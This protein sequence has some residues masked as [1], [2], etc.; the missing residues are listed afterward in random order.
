MNSY[1]P[2]KLP[3][4]N[5]LISFSGGR[6]SG[7]MLYKILEANNGLPERCKVVFANTGREMPETLEFI[8]RC[9]DEW[10]VEIIWLEYD[11]PDNKVAYKQVNFQNASRFGEPFTQLINHKKGLP[12]VLV[13]FCTQEL[14]IRTINRYLKKQG[15]KNWHSAIGIRA[16]ELRRIK[17]DSPKD[18]FIKWY[19]LF[20]AKVTK[21][22]IASFWEKHTFDLNLF[23]HNGQAAKGN[24]DGCFLKSEATLAMMWREHPDRMQWWADIEDSQ[25]IRNNK[26]QVFNPARTF[27][28]LGDFVERQGDW[29]FNDKAMLCQADDGE[30]TGI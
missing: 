8:Q 22:T 29:I 23:A 24:C 20:D 18:R 13:R 16:D 25:P 2:Y 1:N 17:S 26:K 15:W 6:T 3:D 12:N 21:H 27:S 30:C 28:A 19:P 10:N 4:G 7:Y 11:R 14:K 5:V 9:S